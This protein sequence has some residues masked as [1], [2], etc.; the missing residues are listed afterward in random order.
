MLACLLSN[1]RPLEDVNIACIR[2]ALIEENEVS[3]LPES[4]AEAK[5]SDE[6]EIAWD[7]KQTIDSLNDDTVNIQIGMIVHVNRNKRK[8]RNIE[9]GI[10]K[11]VKVTPDPGFNF[12]YDV[13]YIIG[14]GMVKAISKDMFELSKNNPIETNRVL[15]SHDDVCVI[16]TKARKKAYGWVRCN[17]CYGQLHSVCA[18]YCTDEDIP[19]TRI[20]SFLRCPCCAAQEYFKNPIRSRATLM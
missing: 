6:V 15:P 4:I 19:V 1:P 2:S 10:A 9:G 7:G 8:G 14:G 13:K 20:C 12:V 17:K 18:G 3:G 16:C 5:R 11:I